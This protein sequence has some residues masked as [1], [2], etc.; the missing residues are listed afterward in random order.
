MMGSQ[1]SLAL[2]CLA[3]QR[4]TRQR[5]G[6]TRLGGIG[7][8]IKGVVPPWCLTSQCRRQAGPAHMCQAILSPGLAVDPVLLSK[9]LFLAKYPSLARHM[10]ACLTCP[11]PGAGRDPCAMALRVYIP[12]SEA[13]CPSRW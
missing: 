12:N 6:L 9:A 2:P 8:H 10:I 1:K 3:A 5:E 7:V 4:S 11:W 13:L